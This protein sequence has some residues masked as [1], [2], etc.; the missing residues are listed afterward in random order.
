MTVTRYIAIVTGVYFLAVSVMIFSFA[1]PVGFATPYPTRLWVLPVGVILISV[2][3]TLSVM[4]RF[5]DAGGSIYFLPTVLHAGM[6][7]TL[8]LAG[9][10]AGS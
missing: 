1:G 3:G 8:A 6:L 7:I 2:L 10:F 9:I 5:G 4:Y